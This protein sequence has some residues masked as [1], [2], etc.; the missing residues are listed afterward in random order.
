MAVGGLHGWHVEWPRP[1]MADLTRRAVRS[2]QHPGTI[3]NARS[4]V[5]ALDDGPQ[6]ISPTIGE[7]FDASRFMSPVVDSPSPCTIGNAGMV[8]RQRGDS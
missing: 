8:Y 4:V 2:R 6:A 5:A 1:E 3:G 7:S